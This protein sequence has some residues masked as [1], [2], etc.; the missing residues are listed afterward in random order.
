MVL[1]LKEFLE[2]GCKNR[3]DWALFEREYMVSPTND[4][5]GKLNVI[6]VLQTNTIELYNFDKQGW[7]EE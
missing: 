3:H 7:E 6:F 1:L 2:T 4:P 5:T